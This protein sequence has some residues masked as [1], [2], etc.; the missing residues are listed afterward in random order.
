MK[1]FKRVLS[2]LL[3]MVMVLGCMQWGNAVKADEVVFETAQI[4][5]T[6]MKIGWN[7]GNALDSHGAW[8]SGDDPYVYEPAW[9]KPTTTQALLDAVKAA[10][11][12]AVRVPVT[13]YQ[14]LEADGTIKE[15][16]LTRLTEV[17]DAVLAADMYC[18]INIHHDTGATA[19]AWVQADLDVYE[20]NK[21][22]FEAIWRQLA[23]HF[24]DYNA[25]LLFEGY[26][27]I[28]EIGRAHV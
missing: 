26:N 4:A 5:V 27:E 13:F 20:K 11:F 19:T 1:A 18:I 6:Q 14:H 22:Q 25:R 23:E 12:E 17:V 21:T 15:A 8:L 10:G 9:E 7:L 3:V 2:R 24:R 28:L 16:W